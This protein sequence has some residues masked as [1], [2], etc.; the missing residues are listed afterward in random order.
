MPGARGRQA[1]HTTEP[2]DDPLDLPA[3]AHRAGRHP[4][5][6]RLARDKGP[7]QVDRNQPM[8]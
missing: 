6:R 2:V 7:R 3:R 1:V 4:F 8:P 5:R